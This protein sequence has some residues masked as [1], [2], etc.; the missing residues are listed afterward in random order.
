[1][2]KFLIIFL[3][4]TSN[5]AFAQLTDSELID[6]LQRD[7]FKYFWDYAHPI[8]KLSRERIHEADLSFDQNT[9]AIGGSGFGMMNIIVGIENGF[10]TQSEG[11]THLITALEFLKD[12]DRFHGAWPHWVDGN[13]GNVIPFSEFDD[14]GD[15]VETALLCQALICVREY[16]KNGNF[17]EQILAQ[18]ADA[19]WKGVEWD[20]YRNEEN[21]LYWHWSP[22]HAW[23]MNFP[24]R[25][26]NEAL[27][28]YLLAAS[29][30][31]YSISAE[32]YHEGWARNGDITSNASQYDIPVVF[33]HNGAA[34]MVGP[35]FWAH[36]S[37]LALDPRGLSDDY[38]TNYLDVVKN[39]T[40]IVFEYCVANP[41][42]YLGYSENCWGLTASYSRN[43]DGST[44]YA[45]HQP[46]NDKGIITPTAALSS[47]PYT[48]IESLNFLR[49]L[50]E[51]T[52]GEY[53]GIA[54]PYDAFS[55]HYTWKT[56]RYLA[57]DQ[58]TIGP[59]L[60]NH[61]TQLFWNL[62]MNAPEIKQGLLD[63]GFSSTQHDLTNVE[64]MNTTG[65]IEIFPNPTLNSFNIISDNHHIDSDFKIIDNLGKVVLSGRITAENML[66]DFS[67]Q[68]KG[69]Y[70]IIVGE[71]STNALKMVKL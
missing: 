13:T 24:L 23:Q 32:I 4:F 66:I 19:L 47:L 2:R 58:G 9:I 15:L 55:P 14:G 45:A 65:K 28:T 36:Y 62:F 22:N 68:P 50:Y 67:N 10:I 48:P 59:M 53:L 40:E 64:E 37:Y 33:N 6:T 43:T 42:M 12:A 3:V 25:G 18:K 57:I 41:Q 39:H 7:V 31:E 69:V 51:Y 30:P 61:K 52:Q 8:S 29:S 44:G 71:Q 54:G 11:V 60:E 38:A 63:L 26:Y 34:G 35:L 16:F 56:E 1:V 17:Q 70:F 21:V 46:S 49:Y 27:I 5:V 20:W